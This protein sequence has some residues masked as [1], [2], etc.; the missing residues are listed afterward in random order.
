LRDT[1]HLH[2]AKQLNDEIQYLRLLNAASQWQVKNLFTR[3]YNPTGYIT[4]P[5][6]P[7]QN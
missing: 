3:K 1:C 7:Y 5:V 6:N 4:T 2:G